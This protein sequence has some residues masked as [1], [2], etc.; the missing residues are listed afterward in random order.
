MFHFSVEV[1]EPGLFGPW[2]YKIKA[3]TLNVNFFQSLMS[4]KG[5]VFFSPAANHSPR[6]ET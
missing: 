2:I 3:E 6:P 4:R 5:F 1:A